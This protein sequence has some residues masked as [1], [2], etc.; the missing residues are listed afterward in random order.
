MTPTVSVLRVL[1][2]DDEPGVRA[3]MRVI[4]QKLGWAVVE[5]EDGADAY[6]V[7]QETSGN[8]DLLVTDVRMPRMDGLSLAERVR[9]RFSGIPVLFVSAYPDDSR[10][11]SHSVFLPKPFRPQ[12]LITRVQELSKHR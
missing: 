7:M 11:I 10:A 3:Y 2:V 4:L 12:A 1:L 5:A 8:F 6:R 9:D